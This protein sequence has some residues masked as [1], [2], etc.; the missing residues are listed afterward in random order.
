MKTLI[1]AFSLIASLFA[2]SSHAACL[3]GLTTTS[4]IQSRVRGFYV[5]AEGGA[6]NQFV[7]LDKA[8]CTAASSGDATLGLY[9]LQ[10]YLLKISNPNSVLFKEL[11]AAQATG[12]VVSF[13]LQAGAAD[14]TGF[15]QISFVIIPADA[16]NQ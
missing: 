12:E 6:N 14:S 1:A 5:V 13:R 2:L 15:N 8:T 4:T 9:T 16:I 3:D 7:V 11:R 10:N